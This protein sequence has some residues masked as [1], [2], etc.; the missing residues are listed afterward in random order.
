MLLE[1]SD[2]TIVDSDTGQRWDS[3]EHWAQDPIEHERLLA[4]R[5]EIAAQTHPRTGEA[6]C[7]APSPTSPQQSS[8]LLPSQ[9]LSRIEQRR[10]KYHAIFPTMFD[11][12]S[13]FRHH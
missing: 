5:N 11:L 7:D 8:S 3:A 13:Q 2:G 10:A 12:A 1:R 9:L 4:L 6:M